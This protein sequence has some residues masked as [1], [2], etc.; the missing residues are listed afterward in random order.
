[1]SH[2]GGLKLTLQPADHRDRRIRFARVA[3]SDQDGENAR[4]LVTDS[5]GRM[6]FPLPGGDY[7]LSVPGGR[8]L[9]FAVRDQRWTAVRLRLG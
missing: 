9:V 6:R 7:R 8:E 3:L 5:S 4:L 1:M 2:T